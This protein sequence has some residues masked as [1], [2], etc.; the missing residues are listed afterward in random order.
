MSNRVATA[1]MLI[2]CSVAEAFE[3]FTNP[4]KITQFWLEATSGP[5]A[6]GAQVKWTFMVPGA[7][8]TVTVTEFHDQR[9]IAFGWSD[10]LQVALTFQPHGNEGARV[11]VAAT[12]FSSDQGIAEIVDATEGFSVVLCDL[13]TLLESGR[14]A[15][16]VRDKAALIAAARSDAKPD[17]STSS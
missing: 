10:G 11:S 2:R 17:A 5:L 9:R 13:K 7:T 12:G 16:L 8:E 14:S 3:A 15:N 4:D 6:E 1:T